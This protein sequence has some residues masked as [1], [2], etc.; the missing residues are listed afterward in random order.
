MD[1]NGKIAVV[2]G[3]AHGIGRALALALHEAGA[4]K[5]ICVDIDEAGATET[6]AWIGGEGRACDVSSQEQIEALITRVEEVHGPI[7]LFCSN[8]GIATGFDPKGENAAFADADVWQKAWEVNVMAHIHAAR[9]LVP[10]MRARGGGAFL[11]TISAAGLLSQ[12]GS[13][14]YSTTKHA[15]VGFAESLALTHKDHGIQVTILCPQGVATPM[16]DRLIAD[17]DSARNAGALGD[18]VLSAEEVASAALEGVKQGRFLVLPHPEVLKYMQHKTADYDRWIAGM[19][20]LQ[21]TL[22]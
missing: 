22:R 18:G 16:L 7:D 12:V 20:K 4:A 17:D 19:A 6:A 11:N 8:A 3:A 10:R 21:R 13:A 1:I 2:T 9:I 15:A 5:V 14:V